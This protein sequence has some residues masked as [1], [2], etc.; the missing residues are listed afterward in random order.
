MSKRGTAMA[1]VRALA[2]GEHQ[3]ALWP[4]GQAGFLMRHGELALAIEN[5][6]SYESTDRELD[7]TVDESSGWLLSRLGG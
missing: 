2:L 6:R 3:A 4:L 7:R 1:D 5:A